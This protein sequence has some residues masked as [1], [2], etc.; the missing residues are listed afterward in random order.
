MHC[1]LDQVTSRKHHCFA[2]EPIA[3]TLLSP[4]I[5]SQCVL[6]SV[7]AFFFFACI[8]LVA[9]DQADFTETSD[10]DFFLLDKGEDETRCRFS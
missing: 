3:A 6:M 7:V 10:Y 9:L 4:R 5:R 8:M 1:N 2:V